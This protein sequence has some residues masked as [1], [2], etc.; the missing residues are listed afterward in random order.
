MSERCLPFQ[1]L[2]LQLLLTLALLLCSCLASATATLKGTATPWCENGLRLRLQPD[3]LPAAAI[4]TKAAQTALF[5]QRGLSEMPSALLLGDGGCKPGAPGKLSPSSVAVT[6]GNIMAKAQNDGGIGVYAVDTGKLLFA[7]K[8]TFETKTFGPALPDSCVTG[9]FLSGNELYVVNTTVA[10][11]LANCSATAACSGFSTEVVACAGDAGIHTVHFKGP[12][13]ATIANADP[14]WSS[15]SKPRPVT[16]GYIFSS[17]NLAAGDAT[18]RIYGLGQ[19]GWAGYKAS[20]EPYPVGNQSIVPLER[21]GQTINLQ[22]K[23]YHITIPF[24]LSTTSGGQSYG[25]LWNMPGAGQVAVGDAG[26]GGMHWTAEASLGIDIWITAPPKATPANEAVAAIYK[27]Y[28][29]ATGHAPPLRE[30][31]MLFWQSRNRYK[32]SAIALSIAERYADLKLPV[33]VIVI[34]YKNQHVDGD[35]APNSDCYPS[36][37][38]L[39]DGI[40]GSINATTMFSFWPE[41]QN[42]SAEFNT[43]LNAGCL[44]NQDLYGL[45]IDATIPACRNLIWKKFLKP[46]YYD[47]GVSAYWLDETDGEGS[48]KSNT[49]KAGDGPWTGYETS[50]GPSVAY[51]NLWVN[52]WISIFADPIAKLGREPPLILTRGVWAGGQRHGAIL[53]SSDILSTF[54]TLA[55]MVPQGVHTS[56]SGI[57]WW[58]TDVGGYFPDRENQTPF[59]QELIV[60]WYQFGAFCPIFR[61]HGCRT[62]TGSGNSSEP[63]CQEEPDVAPCISNAKGK[64]QGSCAANEVWS[65]GKDTQPMLEKYVRVR[66]QLKPY[67]AELSINVTARGVPTMRPLWYEFPTDPKCVGV[68]DQYLLGTSLLVAPVVIQNATE[69]EVYFPAGAD[70]QDFFDPNAEVVKGGSKQMVQAPL[71]SIP[72][73]WRKASTEE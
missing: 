63:S 42:A 65:Y 45:G 9:P 50:W 70:W 8:A 11:A 60:R 16:T 64:L 14:A 49:G 72:V 17:L 38:A 2:H 59:M 27:Q 30:D 31:A 52:D 37:K 33:G 46:R 61:T 6:S 22:Q 40:R 26:T 54:E 15:W 32:S 1:D 58:T 21:N 51:N 29:D 5:K 20:W 73:Y 25:F 7:A 68:N 13:T 24:A 28:A 71:D 44:M 66:E 19:G 23:K 35:F 62:C 41:A 55:A 47:Q 56:L 69:R 48:D 3:E 53:W 10:D 67:I 18:E 12:K 36:V 4:A 57:P 39:S 34:D 43:L